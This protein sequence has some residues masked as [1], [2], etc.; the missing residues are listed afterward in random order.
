MAKAKT[1]DLTAAEKALGVELF[2]DRSAS[3][4]LHEA[5]TAYRA[6]RR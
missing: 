1:I 2:K 3:Q 6:A 4:A 5:V